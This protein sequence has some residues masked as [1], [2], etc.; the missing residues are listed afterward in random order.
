MDVVDGHPYLLRKALYHITRGSL[1]LEKFVRIAPT[2][3]GLYGDHLRRHLIN[4]KADPELEAAMKQ[5][6]AAAG[7]V[8]VDPSQGFKLRSMGLVPRPIPNWKQR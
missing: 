1:T 8:R 3:E 5:V 4:I 2:E 7:P 6:I